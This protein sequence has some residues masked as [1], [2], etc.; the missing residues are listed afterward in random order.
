MVRKATSLGLKKI[1]Q[2]FKAE[3]TE[4]HDG[5]EAVSG[6]HVGDR[7][8][9]SAQWPVAELGAGTAQISDGS[10]EPPDADVVDPTSAA[11]GAAADDESEGSQPGSFNE[12]DLRALRLVTEKPGLDLFQLTE[13][14]SKDSPVQYSDAMAMAILGRL[15]D[16]GLVNLTTANDY[17]VTDAGAELVGATV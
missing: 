13:E 11:D 2:V 7:A 17:E 3:A 15:T 14:L 8:G 16:G 5:G 12:D 9:E 1:K 4:M 6:E 10:E